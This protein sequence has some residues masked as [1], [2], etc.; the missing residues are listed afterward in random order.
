MAEGLAEAG[1]NV[2]VCA[3]KLE[4]CEQ[5]AA[6]LAQLGVRTLALACDVRSPE[7][8]QSVV[9]RTLEELGAVDVLVSNAGTGWGGPPEQMPLGGW[10]KG[11]DVNLTGVF[12]FAQAAGRA[13]IEGGGGATVN[14]ASVPRLRWG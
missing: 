3:R 2:V 9:D 11:I 13:M 7:Q 6:E 10:Q 14:I 4:R 12:L 8:V 5:A 1:A